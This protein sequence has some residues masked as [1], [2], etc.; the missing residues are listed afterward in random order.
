MLR[1][2]YADVAASGV[3]V[4]LGVMPTYWTVTDWRSKAGFLGLTAR[5]M[6]STTARIRRAMKENKRKRQQQHPLKEAE[7]EWEEF[8]G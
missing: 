6:M 8:V 1:E 2:T 7:E 5:T 4:G 3:G